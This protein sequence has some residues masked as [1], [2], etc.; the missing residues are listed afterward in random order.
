MAPIESSSIYFQI[1]TYS[2]MYTHCLAVLG[3]HAVTYLCIIA[4]IYLLEIPFAHHLNSLCALIASLPQ[5]NP[6]L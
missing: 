3:E 1:L 5:E 2:H 6:T 4:N